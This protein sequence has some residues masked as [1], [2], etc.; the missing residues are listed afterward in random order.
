MRDSVPAYLPVIGGGSEKMIELP[1][2]RNNR[3]NP[4]GL[5]ISD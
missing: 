5:P 2:F 4:K 3:H 1:Q